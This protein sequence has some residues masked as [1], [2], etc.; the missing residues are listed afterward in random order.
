MQTRCSFLARND[1]F[2]RR[3][4]AMKQAWSLADVNSTRAIEMDEWMKE[5]KQQGIHN[6]IGNYNVQFN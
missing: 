3:H 5:Y 2:N 1:I 6:R 4:N